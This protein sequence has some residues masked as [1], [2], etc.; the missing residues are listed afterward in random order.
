MRRKILAASAALALIVGMSGFGTAVAQEG[1]GQGR[2][3]GGQGQPMDPEQ[4]RARMMDNLKERLG[5]SDEEWQ[6]LQPKVEGV[7]AAQMNAR[8]GAMM[9]MAMGRGG[10]GGGPG[11]G[12]GR[13]PGGPEGEPTALMTAGRELRELLQDEAAGNDAIKEKL[14]AFRGAR[15]QSETEL[16][17]ARAELQGLVTLRQ[18]ALL[19]AMGLL[20]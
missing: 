5:A 15:K 13:G 10:P 14:E 18:E 8:T 3:G 20:E 1:Q 7:L 6:A 16:D 19:V 17:A 12:A 9:G 2:R 11:G 4:A